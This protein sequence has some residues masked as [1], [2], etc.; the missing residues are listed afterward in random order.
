MDGDKN[1]FMILNGPGR[2]TVVLFMVS[3]SIKKLSSIDQGII[4]LLSII[5]SIDF[6][7]WKSVGQYGWR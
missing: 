3:V 5:F 6:A 4:Y 2:V 1:Y 7:W